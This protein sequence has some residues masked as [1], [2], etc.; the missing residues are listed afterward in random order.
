VSKF[1]YVEIKFGTRWTLV[2]THTRQTDALQYVKDNSGEKYPMRIVRV[3]RT[4]V[5]DGSKS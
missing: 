4:V 1:Y 2:E 3:V 5:F